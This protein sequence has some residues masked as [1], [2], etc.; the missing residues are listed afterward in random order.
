MTTPTVGVRVTIPTA[1]MN[2]RRVRRLL[3]TIWPDR[4]V[5]TREETG[6]TLAWLQLPAPDGVGVGDVLDG[7]RAQLATYGAR[8]DGVQV[9]RYRPRPDATSRG[10]RTDQ[11][12][13]WRRGAAVVPGPSPATPRL[14]T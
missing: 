2:N 9:V 8:G 6:R 13:P 3:D 1:V 14:E 10:R 5:G 11:G 7:V 12:S 4:L